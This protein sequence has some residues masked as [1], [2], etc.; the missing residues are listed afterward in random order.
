MSTEAM[1]IG[2]VAIVAILIVASFVYSKRVRTGNR[3][4]SEQLREQFGSEYDRTIVDKGD[5]R[6]AESD[7]A[8]RQKRV[9]KF[10]IRPLAADEGQRFSDEWQ[11][12]QASFVD[13]PSIAVRDADALLGRVMEARG[14][15]AGDFEQRYADVSV[16]HPAALDHYRA[17][18]ETTL[19]DAKGEANTED[20]RQAFINDHALFTELVDAPKTVDAVE[21]A[22]ETPVL[23]ATR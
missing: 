10:D 7:L 20:L 17:A 9:S 19:L 6:H 18:H 11:V 21:A 22:D 3:Q 23:V 8:A 14:Y 5:I 2:A 13:D 1:I 16:D 12:V 4:R 15:P